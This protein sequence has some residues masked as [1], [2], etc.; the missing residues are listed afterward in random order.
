MTKSH[1]V[2][3]GRVIN[4]GA[5]PSGI[6]PT[7]SDLKN[8]LNQSFGTEALASSRRSLDMMVVPG[9]ANEVAG[10]DRRFSCCLI[11]EMTCIP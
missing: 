7:S 6:I 9:E 1:Q 2:A 11:A 3:L 10:S 5:I 4:C 8:N